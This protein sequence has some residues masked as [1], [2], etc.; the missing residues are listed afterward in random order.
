MLMGFST[1]IGLELE[2]LGRTQ[3]CDVAA[4]ECLLCLWA[5]IP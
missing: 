5:L 4:V 2:L 3:D 1:V